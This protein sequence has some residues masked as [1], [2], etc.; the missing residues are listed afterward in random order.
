[1]GEWRKRECLSQVR[2]MEKELRKASSKKQKRIDGYLERQGEEFLK[3][4][5]QRKATC[6][7][8]VSER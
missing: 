1:M 2:E 5:Q 8:L 4:N 6:L 7:D 3:R